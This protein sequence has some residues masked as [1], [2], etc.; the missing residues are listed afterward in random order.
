MYIYKYL[1]NGKRFAVTKMTGKAFHETREIPLS[2]RSMIIGEVLRGKSFDNIY[3]GQ[4]YREL[5][6]KLD[7]IIRSEGLTGLYQALKD[8]DMEN[9]VREVFGEK[10]IKIMDKW[11]T[12]HTA[13]SKT[14]KKDIIEAIMSMEI[15]LS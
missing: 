11:N 6:L 14:K 9:S 3:I 13:S 5:K 4:K 8:R 2:Q 10:I 7:T 1:F 15:G 12:I